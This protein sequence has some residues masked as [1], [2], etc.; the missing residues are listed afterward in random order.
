MWN[1]NHSIEYKIIIDRN[2][3]LN[4]PVKKMDQWTKMKKTNSKKNTGLS[5]PWKEVNNEETTKIFK[6]MIS[7]D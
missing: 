1:L 6:N 5:D 2:C 7:C 3:E 4:S